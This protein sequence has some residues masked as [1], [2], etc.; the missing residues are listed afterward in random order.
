[1]T[2]P[3]RSRLLALVAVGLSLLSANT[4]AQTTRLV[5]GRPATRATAIPTDLDFTPDAGLRMADAA[6]AG[7]T[8]DSGTGVFWLYCNVANQP[9]RAFSSDGLTFDTPLPYGD[10]ENNP[11]NVLM[12][13]PTPG[14]QDLW[15]RYF[16]DVATGDFTS[17]YSHDG[18]YY[19]PEG[20]VRYTLQPE[21]NG[22]MGIHSEYITAGG[23]VVLL[24][25]GD[26]GGVN[27]IRRALSWDNGET[28]TFDQGDILNDA[29]LGGTGMSYVDQMTLLLPD[30]RRRMF[31]MQQGPQPPH[32][33][34][35]KVGEIYSFI[36]NDEIN[37]TSEVG[38]LL[39]CEDFTEFEVYSL[40]DPFVI[41]LP[42]G[43]YRMYVTA[44][45]EDGAGGYMW[46]IV[47]ATTS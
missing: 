22:T 16:M 8:Y 45:V 44:K 31:V 46:A 40:N 34:L 20:G 12:P 6:N 41:I 13:Q 42:D 33:P 32:P 3:L 19:S 25:I 4:Q 21:D 23:A 17:A 35:R 24:Y 11:R 7:P 37:Y 15:R 28:F 2:H 1:M 39:V 5:P 27:N 36:S 14:G 38:P 26:L 10:H 29:A 30:G 47:S 18:I 43:R 9:R